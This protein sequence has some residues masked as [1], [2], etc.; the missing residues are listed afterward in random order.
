MIFPQFIVVVISMAF[1][2]TVE[3]A[4]SGATAASCAD[5][6]PQHGAF[7]PQTTPSPYS[8][9]INQVIVFLIKQ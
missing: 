3:A 5:M 8:I 9:S 1:L 6:L 4:S 7:A 2:V